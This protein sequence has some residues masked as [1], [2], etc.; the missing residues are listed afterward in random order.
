MIARAGTSQRDV[1]GTPKLGTTPAPGVAGRASRPAVWRTGIPRRPGTVGAA[2]VFRE[3]AE[4]RT[5]GG[6]APHSTSVDGLNHTPCEHR[7]QNAF[8]NGVHFGYT[9]GMRE[10]RQSARCHANLPGVRCPPSS[11]RSGFS[12]VE[13]LVVFALL[14]ALTTMMW[15][16]GSPSHQA[17]QKQACAANLQ[18]IHVALELYARDSGGEFP[19]AAGA[20]TSEEVL[21]VLVP[22]YTAD[23]SLFICPGS[24]DKPLPGGESLR[25]Q[26]ISY[27]Y[28]MG[29][30]LTNA[31][32]LLMSDRQIDTRGRAAGERAFSDTGKPPGNNHHKYGGNFLFSDGHVE[33]TPARVPFSLETTQGIVLLNPK[34]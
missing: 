28:Y 33:S 9:M 15:G 13:G 23:T 7:G 11:A 8:A 16:F 24:K 30:R 31:M 25:K 10:L 12:L 29:R 18:K 22:R 26:R 32:E 5:R 17:R 14:I 20:R 3:G 1:P 6:C 21:D 27:A 34:P 19:I 2:E 4:N